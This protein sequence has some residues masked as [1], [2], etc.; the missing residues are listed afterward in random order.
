MWWRYKKVNELNMQQEMCLVC[1]FIF[2]Y[3][4]II[5][6]WSFHKGKLSRFKKQYLDK[7]VFHHMYEE[8]FQGVDQHDRN[9]SPEVD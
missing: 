4:L 8:D 3:F 9:P 5:Q 1:V 6:R 7:L 2:Y